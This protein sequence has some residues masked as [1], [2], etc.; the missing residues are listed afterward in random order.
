[1]MKPGMAH[2]AVLLS[3]AA[4][5]EGDRYGEIIARSTHAQPGIAGGTGPGRRESGL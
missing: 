2:M 3:L 1:M 5:A 4:C